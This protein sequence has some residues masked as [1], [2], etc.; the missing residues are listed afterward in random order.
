MSGTHSDQGTAGEDAAPRPAEPFCWRCLFAALPPLLLTLL[1][2]WFAGAALERGRLQV[3]Q[4]AGSYQEEADDL[5][6]QNAGLLSDLSTTRQELAAAR[7]ALAAEGVAGVDD[8]IE[9]LAALPPEE[10]AALISRAGVDLTPKPTTP[11][12]MLQA[13]DTLEPPVRADLF[14]ALPSAPAFSR[15]FEGLDAKAKRAWLEGFLGEAANAIEISGAPSPASLKRTEEREAALLRE[16]RQSLLIATLQREIDAAHSA[17]DSAFEALRRSEVAEE[18]TK[19]VLKK[20]TEERD[21]ARAGLAAAQTELAAAQT[22]LAA[23]NQERAEAIQALAEARSDGETR[24]ATLTQTRADL[25][26]L[27]TALAD[28]GDAREEAATEA[29][30]EMRRAI[31]EARES[32][33]AA[34]AGDP[35]ALLQR[36]AALPARQRRTVYAD[37]TERLPRDPGYGAWL[38]TNRGHALAAFSSVIEPAATTASGSP[39]KNA[40]DAA[41]ARIAALE[42]RLA[43]RGAEAERWRGEAEQARQALAA[44]EEAKASADSELATVRAELASLKAR[45]AG[46]ERDLEKRAKALESA[47]AALRDRE[48]GLAEAEKRYEALT[49]SRAALASELS[50][51]QE[52]ARK[53]VVEA[54]TGRTAA[55]AA[56]KRAD[57]ERAD[58]AREAAERAEA[59]ERRAETAETALREAE[60]ASA[61]AEAA[62]ASATDRAEKAERR[63]TQL[64]QALAAARTEKSAP[65]PRAPAPALSLPE[66]GVISL[67]AAP[68]A[69][70]RLLSERDAEI[71]ALKESVVRLER[72]AAESPSVQ[73]AAAPE[74]APAP[75]AAPAIAPGWRPTAI[76]EIAENAPDNIAASVLFASASADL[77]RSGRR[78]VRRLGL[79]LIK[80]HEA[81]PDAPWRLVVEGHTDQLPMRGGEFASNWALSA[82]RAAA[83]TQYLNYLGVPQERLTAVGLGASRPK[84][85]RWTREAFKANRRIELKML[86]PDVQS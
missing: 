8:L 72:E 66:L 57:G 24:R 45:L 16:K 60:E 82:A 6:A 74:E 28:A 54:Q 3:E 42:S 58:A 18:E 30:A 83:V 13:I 14:A 2:G 53:A 64:D 39:G 86:T 41:A 32:G 85:P 69:V 12:E 22:Q 23:S 67:D 1:F 65:P 76:R 44:A 51:A 11:Q 55:L 80:A 48:Q 52:T 21:A 29:S 43:E 38:E 20:T 77:T 31:E 37:L 9:R 79:A 35:A 7:A 40:G 25:A 36:I 4:H 59:A 34:L 33:R 75:A 49:R 46:L 78:A 56:M 5:F 63:A 81:D 26:E 84:D 10:R 50:A 15:W 71:A 27:R 17:K 61:G 68:T 19:A 47:E 62:L 73:A 70:A